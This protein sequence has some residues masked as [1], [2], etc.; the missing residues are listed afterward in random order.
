MNPLLIGLGAWLFTLAKG[1]KT[2]DRLEYSPKNLEIINDKLVY[3]MDVLNP[4][5]NK[6][7]VDSFFAGIFADD[8]KIGTI[9]RGTP[10]DL[11]PNKR[12]TVK[13]PVRLNA[14]GLAKFALNPT[15]LSKMKFKVSGIARA[16]GIDNPVTQ[17]LSLNA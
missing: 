2:A 10:F 15:K 14:I 12:T 16:L 13:L 8:A 9:E 1:Q 4:T 3:T 17:D 11:A 6:L 5:K 7:K